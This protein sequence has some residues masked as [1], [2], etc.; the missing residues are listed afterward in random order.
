VGHNDSEKKKRLVKAKFAYYYQAVQDV[1]GSLLAFKTF[2]T[3]LQHIYESV[4][5]QYSNEKRALAHKIKF[6]EVKTAF[7]GVISLLSLVSMG[8]GIG[9]AVNAGADTVAQVLEEG[10]KNFGD[11]AA[12]LAM[13]VVTGALESVVMIMQT[14]GVEGKT[15]AQAAKAQMKLVIKKM[16]IAALVWCLAEES[17]VTALAEQKCREIPSC[18][19]LNN[20]GST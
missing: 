3:M 14:I 6:E 5:N 9:D 2:C 19:K 17:G 7:A 8:I 16:P 12:E 20:L 10:A 18:K 13:P 15:T 1:T 11:Y 4:L